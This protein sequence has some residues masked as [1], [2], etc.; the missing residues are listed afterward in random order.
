M[1]CYVT[2]PSALKIRH[3]IGIEIIAWECD[4]PHSDSIFP[5]APE[6]VLAEMKPAEVSDD[7]INMITWKN[8]CRFFGWDPFIRIPADQAT[9]ASL[10]ALAT[11]VDTA[12]RPKSEWRALYERRTA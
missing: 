6:F 5:N 10:R 7:E 3:D 4:Y 2:D 8:T 9:V 11:D 12:V 1:A